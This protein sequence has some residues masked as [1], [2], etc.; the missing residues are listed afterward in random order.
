[1]NPTEAIQ[2][3]KDGNSVLNVTASMLMRLSP[4]GDV[5]LRRED[6]NAL[7]A[8]IYGPFADEDLYRLA[9]EFCWMGDPPHLDIGRVMQVRHHQL[10]PQA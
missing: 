4:M 7:V 1:M 9:Q 5:E 2:K 6:G 10:Q 3:L 8:V